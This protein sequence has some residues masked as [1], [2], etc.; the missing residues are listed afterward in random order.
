MHAIC[1]MGK[2]RATERTPCGNGSM[3]KIIMVME[4]STKHNNASK[5]RVF[6]KGY[7]TGSGRVVPDHYRSTPYIADGPKGTFIERRLA[8]PKR[9]HY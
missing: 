7:T 4:H 6:V 2:H 5:K 1:L 8:N 3:Q 9:R